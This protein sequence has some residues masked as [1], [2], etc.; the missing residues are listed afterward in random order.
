M[1]NHTDQPHPIA[2][3]VSLEVAEARREMALD[4]YE[5]R[6]RRAECW[7]GDTEHRNWG[8]PPTPTEMK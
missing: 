6:V 8:H 7:T 2:P 4:L 1:S 5:I 3:R